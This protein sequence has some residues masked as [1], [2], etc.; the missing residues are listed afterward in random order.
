MF[1]MVLNGLQWSQMVLNGLKKI[2]H[3]FNRMAFITRFNLVLVW[4]KIVKMLTKKS[5]KWDRHNQVSWSSF[6]MILV[7]L[8]YLFLQYKSI[9]ILDGKRITNFTTVSSKSLQLL[10]NVPF[11]PSP[12]LLE[13]NI[14]NVCYFKTALI[15]TL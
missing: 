1:N 12:L 7:S 4:S 2:D 15:D 9:A 6:I 3:K 11:I 14:V 13:Y 8:V 10:S 5:S